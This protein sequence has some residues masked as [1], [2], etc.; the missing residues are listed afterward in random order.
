MKVEC[1]C[2]ITNDVLTKCNDKPAILAM[3]RPM[4]M[5]E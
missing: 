5:A 1:G 4:P 3:E 2:I